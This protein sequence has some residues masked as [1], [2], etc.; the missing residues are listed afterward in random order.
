MAGRACPL[1][2]GISDLDLRSY[3]KGVINLNPRIAHSALDLGVPQ[4]QLHRTQ[5]RPVGARA[6]SDAGDPCGDEPDIAWEV[7]MLLKTAHAR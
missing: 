4:E 5:V 1:C 3:R 6:Q 7:S 2:L